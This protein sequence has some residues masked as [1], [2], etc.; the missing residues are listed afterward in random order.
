VFQYIAPSS[1]ITLSENSNRY[2][3]KGA[4]DETGWSFNLNEYP[5]NDFE[6]V[7][8][9]L[10][11]GTMY[12]FSV[13]NN[14]SANFDVCLAINLTSTDYIT[15]V[16]NSAYS[17]NLLQV[18]GVPMWD[19]YDTWDNIDFSNQVAKGIFV[20]SGTTKDFLI[21]VS[22]AQPVNVTWLVLLTGTSNPLNN[23]LKIEW[24]ELDLASGLEIKYSPLDSQ[25]S[26]LLPSESSS[27][28]NIST[29]DQADLTKTILNETLGVN[30]TITMIRWQKDLSGN[31]IRRTD[32]FNGLTNTLFVP[33]FEN[34]QLDGTSIPG[35]IINENLEDVYLD[36]NFTATATDDT[37]SYNASGLENFNVEFELGK[38][39]LAWKVFSLNENEYFDI[40]F[41]NTNT[42]ALIYWDISVDFYAIGAGNPSFFTLDSFGDNQ[43]ETA[44]FFASSG[45]SEYQ[46]T[47]ETITP[48]E[49]IPMH[50]WW[51]EHGIP[52]QAVND[53][54]GTHYLGLLISA[55]TVDAYLNLT[56][57]ITVNAKNLSTFENGEA[58]EIGSDNGLP[59]DGFETFHVR[60][61]EFANFTQYEWEMQSNTALFDVNK[62]LY[63][64]DVDNYLDDMNNA[65]ISDSFNI[66]TLDG[67]ITLEFIMSAELRNDNLYLYVQNSTTLTEIASFTGSIPLTTFQYDISAYTDSSVQIILNMTSD[68]KFTRS[69]PVIDDVSVSNQ[70]TTVFFDDFSGDLTDLWTQVDNT[71][72]GLLFWNIQSESYT[73]STPALD[74]VYPN[75]IGTFVGYSVNP[76]I[77]NEFVKTELKYNPFVQKGTKGYI[78]YKTDEDV[79]YQNFSMTVNHTAFSPIN[80]EEIDEIVA[81]HQYPQVTYENYVYYDEIQESPEFYEYFYLDIEPDTIYEIEF[82][83]D[84]I[85]VVLLYADLFA[86]DGIG[87]RA[88]F[89]DHYG[90][91]V[92]NGS[93]QFQFEEAKRVYIK[94]DAIEH[95]LTIKVRAETVKDTDKT[96][97]NLSIATGIFAAIA[98]GS[99]GFIG[100]ERKDAILSTLSK[101]KK[102]KIKTDSSSSKALK[103]ALSKTPKDS[104]ET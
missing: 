39:N 59:F 8:F 46:N 35:I 90:F 102:P 83:Y 40:S 38:T 43:S 5:L 42:D 63:C 71:D 17:D 91:F 56:C 16:S 73:Y 75:S 37:I 49:F 58:I 21:Y 103:D 62:R 104:G 98:A 57:E 101:I 69:G 80:L 27:I 89:P 81:N 95:G 18:A 4:F 82:T 22:D 78:I 34:L 79:L 48:F 51:A 36:W 24:E 74:I 53:V 99:L 96:I 2:L 45:N 12:N 23:T 93:Y 68:N 11:R 19:D 64:R 97:R 50:Y 54:G 44:T 88:N 9:T 1:N 52:D 86:P 100:Y 28:L 92:I 32:L 67:T 6:E 87:S 66:L 26:S 76:E 7:P 15:Q 84:T 55:V 20:S 33:E 13:L 61:F 25:V 30:D 29:V 41:G 72:S 10:E 70:T 94:L 85:D 31:S 47:Q 65:L 77:Y 60:E 14:G 3:P